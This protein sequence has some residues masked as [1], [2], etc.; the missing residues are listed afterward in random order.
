METGRQDI[1]QSQGCIVQHGEYGQYFIIIVK[2]KVI[3]QNCV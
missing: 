2:W 1:R 3:F